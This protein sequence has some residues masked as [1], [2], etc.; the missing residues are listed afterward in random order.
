MLFQ[1]LI[2]SLKRLKII[3]IRVKLIFFYNNINIF[4]HDNITIKITLINCYFEK[5][6][7]KQ[8]LFNQFL[9]RFSTR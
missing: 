5:F 3:F 6:K 9:I 8:R 1:Y 7:I 4:Y 2:K